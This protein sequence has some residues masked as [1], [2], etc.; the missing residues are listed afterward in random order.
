MT[1]ESESP[2]NTST[3]WARLP[4]WQHIALIV[5][6]TVGLFAGIANFLVSDSNR[7]RAFHVV[8]TVLDGALLVILVT[9]YLARTQE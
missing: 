5:L 1:P 3:G 2:E 8:F 4:R 6:C 7:A 9:A